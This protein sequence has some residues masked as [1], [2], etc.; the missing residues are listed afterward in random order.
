MLGSKNDHINLVV[1][2][3]PKSCYLSEFIRKLRRTIHL[4][5]YAVE[6][7]SAEGKPQGQI[8]NWGRGAPRQLKCAGKNKFRL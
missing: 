2:T 1:N 5:F 8:Y 7:T 4:R 6:L 3:V